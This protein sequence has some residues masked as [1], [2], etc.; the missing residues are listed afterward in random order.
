MQEQS[1]FSIGKTERHPNVRTDILLIMDTPTEAYE[2]LLK[3][4][5]GDPKIIGLVFGSSR[6]KDNQFLT[7]HSDYDVI[8]VLVDD[9]SQELKDHLKMY[10]SEKFELWPK[11]ITEFKEHA[12][13]G[14]ADDWDRY[15]YTHNKAVIDKTGEIQKIIDGK[16]GL[17]TEV[18]KDFVENALDAYINSVYRS[19]K[20]WRDGNEFAAHVDASE[21]LPYLMTA[22]Y[23]LEGRL[24]PYNKY[25]VWEL[26]NH[27][28]KLLPWSVDGFISDYKKI[29]VAGDIKTQG[30][31]YTAVK[32]LFQNQGYGKTVEGWKGKYFVG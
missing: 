13:W 6:G 14:T 4:A 18:Q 17:P 22:L 1:I 7:E 25:F 32:K 31:I 21:S 29:L 20:Y 28:L 19:A 26:K 5:Q 11:T 8:V 15:N 24:K 27:P 30:K 3:E 23:A 16:G 12:R 10:E 9:A 2:K